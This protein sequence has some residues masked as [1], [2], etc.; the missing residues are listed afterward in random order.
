MRPGDIPSSAIDAIHVPKVEMLRGPTQEPPGARPA[1]VQRS[2]SE[3]RAESGWLA[4]PPALLTIGGWV[5]L[6]LALLGLLAGLVSRA[7]R[8]PRSSP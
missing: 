5:A 6:G 3:R 7:V 1:R 2:D 8:G 4:L